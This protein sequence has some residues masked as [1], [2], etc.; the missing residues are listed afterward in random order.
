MSLCP[1]CGGTT[2]EELPGNQRRC[3]ECGLGSSYTVLRADANPSAKARHQA[4]R[5]LRAHQAMTRD[6]FAGATFT[7]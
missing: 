7:P 4:E 1:R 2:W 5:H 6:A 3:T